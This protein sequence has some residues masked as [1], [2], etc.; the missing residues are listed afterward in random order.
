MRNAKSYKVTLDT[1]EGGE[2][3]IEAQNE[4]QAFRLAWKWAEAGDWSVK[5]THIIRLYDA[6]TDEFLG[7]QRAVLEATVVEEN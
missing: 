1:G 7:E 6:E 3:T 5:E 4:S 2:T